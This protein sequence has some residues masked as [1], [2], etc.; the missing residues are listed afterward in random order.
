MKKATNV[1]KTDTGLA[2][3]EIIRPLGKGAAG[4]VTLVRNKA[5]GG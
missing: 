2:K 5:D 4:E 3:Y 1:N